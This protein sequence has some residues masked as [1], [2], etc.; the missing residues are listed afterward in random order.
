MDLL[1]AIVP[2][3]LVIGLS[4]LPIMPIILILMGPRARA[5]STAYLLAWLAALLAFATLAVVLADAPDPDPVD[6]AGVGWVQVA[7]GAVFIILGA[8]KWLRRPGPDD[9]PASPAWMSA[10]DSYTPARAARL[11]AMLAVANPKN[12]LITLTAA[13]EIAV[14]AGSPGQQAIALL[15]FTAVGSLGVIAPVVA[16]RALGD[17][18]ATVLEGWR[19]WLEANGTMLVVGVLVVLGAFLM[20]KGLGAAG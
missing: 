14:L 12:V 16:H 7:T 17:R 3:A 8:V 11:G 20:A 13:V 5:S 1:A 9:P 18:A 10:L 4:P 6:E 2:L 19:R 15:A